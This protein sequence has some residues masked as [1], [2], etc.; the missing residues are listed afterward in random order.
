MFEDR[1][2]SRGE[3][4]AY[5]AAGVLAGASLLG[6]LGVYKQN[7]ADNDNRDMSR[8]RGRQAQTYNLQLRSVLL[9]E[10]VK[11]SGL[12]VDPLSPTFEV[13]R[14]VAGR[15]ELCRGEFV[16]EDGVA[17]MAGEL[18]CRAEITPQEEL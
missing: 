16:V 15:E 12:I 3:V 17:K 9:E 11:A 14:E 7:K 18:V 4:G 8:D 2:Y 6:G 13:T 1:R 5:A 10:D